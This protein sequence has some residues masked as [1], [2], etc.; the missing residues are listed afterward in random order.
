MGVLDENELSAIADYTV[1]HV[2]V[3]ERHAE[4]PRAAFLGMVEGGMGVSDDLFD[5]GGKFECHV[6]L[7]SSSIERVVY[8]LGALVRVREKSMPAWWKVLMSPANVSS[9]ARKLR[10]NE[11][12][13]QGLEIDEWVQRECAVTLSAKPEP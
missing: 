8:F 13:E 12:R 7:V 3:A 11:H 6:D 5:E 2:S 4:P 9:P 10:A 1:G